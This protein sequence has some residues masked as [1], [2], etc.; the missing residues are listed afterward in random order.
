MSTLL[1]GLLLDLEPVASLDRQLVTGIPLLCLQSIRWTNT[2]AYPT[3][4]ALP[5][6]WHP[7]SRPHTGMARALPV[8]PLCSPSPLPQVDVF[9]ETKNEHNLRTFIS[10]KLRGYQGCW[11]GGGGTG[12]LAWV[13]FVSVSVC[14]SPC[15]RC[16]LGMGSCYHPS[17]GWQTPAVSGDLDL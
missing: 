12:L 9:K 7:N 13:E 4:S 6:F 17:P 3:S 15:Q 2:G 14:G 11:G 8:S 1:R 5:G 10:E 16:G